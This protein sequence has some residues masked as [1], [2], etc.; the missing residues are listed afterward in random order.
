MWGGHGGA[1]DAV[2]GGVGTDP[3]GCDAAA[4]GEDVDTTSEVGVGGPAVRVGG[5]TNGDGV[6][7]GG[8]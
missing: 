7:S 1:G 3:G 2:A 6:R 8:R 5:G 4:G